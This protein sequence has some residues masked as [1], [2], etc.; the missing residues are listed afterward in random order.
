M[1]VPYCRGPQPLVS[2]CDLLRTRPHSRKWAAGKRVKLH[3]YLQLL[4]ISGITAWAPPPVRSAVALDSHRNSNPTVNCACKGSMLHTPY[5]NLMPDDL[6]WSWGGAAGAWE[7][8]QIQI[9]ISREV[10]LHTDHNK[11]IACTLNQNPISEWQVTIKLHLVAGFKSESD[12]YFS[13]YVAHPLFYLPL[14]SAPLSCTAYLSQS[15]FW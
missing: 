7:W 13:P 8:L 2:V 15:Q 5:E 3:L 9:I 14:L 6:R 12:T 11:S 10:W 4:L 1:S